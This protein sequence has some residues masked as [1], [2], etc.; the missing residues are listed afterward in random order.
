MPDERV[1]RRSHRFFHWP[2]EF[3][4]IFHDAQGHP[5]DAPGFD[6]VLGNPPWEMLRGDQGTA[7]TR[8]DAR[9]AGSRVSPTSCAG[10]GIYRL[11]GDG[12]VNLYQLFVERALALLRPGARLGLIL[13]SGFAIDHGCA[14][15]RRA[16]FDRTH[17]DT[18]HGFENRDGLF[19]IHR[20]LKFLLT[21]APSRH[22][23]RPCRHDSACDAPKRST[24]CL[25]PA[26][27]RSPYRCLAIAAG[28]DQRSAAGRA[29]NPQPRID[30][31]IV[32]AIAFSAPPLADPEGWHVTFGRELNATDDKR[33]FV[34]GGDRPSG[35]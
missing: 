11:Q 16:L 33:H 18:L 19:P 4:E 27:T 13:P 30:L 7:R 1:C 22:A 23:R 31:D 34:T 5:L 29:G 21:T 28:E 24:S 8:A 35:H 32:S 25:T 15:L 10:S 2:L 14:A 12:H 20:G 17:V 3:P 9:I 6:A 26:S